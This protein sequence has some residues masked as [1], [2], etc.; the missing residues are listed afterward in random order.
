[1]NHDGVNG[2]YSVWYLYQWNDNTWLKTFY[3]QLFALLIVTQWL[4]T[5]KPSLLNPAFRR[6][7]T[8]K[9]GCDREE[10]GETKTPSSS[11]TGHSYTYAHDTAPY[12]YPAWLCDP[13]SK[14][15][16]CTTRF[17]F[18]SSKYGWSGP[19]RYWWTISKVFLRWHSICGLHDCSKWIT[20][21]QGSNRVAFSFL[22]AV[23]Q[24]AQWL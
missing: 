16:I 2:H 14:P 4:I 12:W 10:S 8:K 9:K 19:E 23:V 20:R 1:M 17:N 7:G 6:E 11:W 24:H 15:N 13:W 3:K 5:N 21:E 22:G 18:K